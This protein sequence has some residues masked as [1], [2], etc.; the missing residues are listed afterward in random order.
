MPFATFPHGEALHWACPL[1]GGNRR[2]RF[3]LSLG[4]MLLSLASL[5]WAAAFSTAA[6]PTTVPSQALYLNNESYHVYLSLAEKGY[7]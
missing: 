3:S 2:R 4:V 6:W 5:Y 7:L 1:K